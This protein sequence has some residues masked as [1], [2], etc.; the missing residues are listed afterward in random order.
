MCGSVVFLKCSSDVEL[1]PYAA[2]KAAA[3][4]MIV[5]SFIAERESKTAYAG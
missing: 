2:G 3:L 5:E 4:E 1:L